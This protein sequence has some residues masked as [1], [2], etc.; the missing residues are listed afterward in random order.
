MM[1]WWADHLHHL[2]HGA[3]IVPIGRKAAAM[4]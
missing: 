4:E 1:Q 3:D 2:E